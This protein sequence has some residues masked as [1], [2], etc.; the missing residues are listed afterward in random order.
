MA[1]YTTLTGSADTEGSIRNWVNVANVPATTVLTEAEAWLAPRLRLREMLTVATGTLTINGQTLALPT[2]FQS[3]RHLKITGETAAQI[4]RR[5]LDVVEGMVGYDT[6]GAV[7][8]GQPVAFYIRG[9]DIVFDCRA[10]DDYPYQL[11]YYGKL[12]AL[13]ETSNE[14][15]ALTERF[16]SLLRAACMIFVSE[17]MKDDAEKQWW[18]AK[19]EIYIREANAQEDQRWGEIADPY[20]D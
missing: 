19:A 8:T 10:D 17:F 9:S 4:I 6:T 11:I 1:N 18:T 7:T 2:G 16:P 13:V 12:A 3:A 5:P 14:T 20:V 15:N